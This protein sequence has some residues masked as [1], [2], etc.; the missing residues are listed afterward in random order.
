MADAPKADCAT[1]GRMPVQHLHRQNQEVDDTCSIA[2]ARMLIREQTGRDV[3]EAELAQ[4][5]Q[6]L[7]AYTPGQ[8]TNTQSQAYHDLLAEYGVETR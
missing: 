4:R 2:S 1:C 5:A 6:E 3:P 8:G 7:G